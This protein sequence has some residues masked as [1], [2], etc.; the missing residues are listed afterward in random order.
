VFPRIENL[1][2]GDSSSGKLFASEILSDVSLYI[3]FLIWCLENHL[4]VLSIIILIWLG[5]IREHVENLKFSRK[6]SKRMTLSCH[7]GSRSANIISGD[8]FGIFEGQG[9]SFERKGSGGPKLAHFF[10]RPITI[11]CDM[12]VKA[13][14]HKFKKMFPNLSFTFDGFFSS[15]MIRPWQWCR[16]W[17]ARLPLL[18]MS[19]SGS[20]HLLAKARRNISSSSWVQLP[21]D[22]AWLTRTI[23]T[24]TYW[25]VSD[26]NLSHQIR[27]Y[28]KVT[29]MKTPGNVDIGIACSRHSKQKEN[30]QIRLHISEKVRNYC[31]RKTSEKKSSILTIWKKFISSTSWKK[32]LFNI[33][34]DLLH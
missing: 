16:A 34:L 28:K 30:S 33:A 25:Q 32:F 2:S 4:C 12:M 13:L 3:K 31:F 18:L 19:F 10:E 11:I 27:L 14:I 1:I 5:Y 9:I 21:L 6:D 7:L 23:P 20:T 15:P 22:I 26:P 29:K 17:F 8:Q 24:P